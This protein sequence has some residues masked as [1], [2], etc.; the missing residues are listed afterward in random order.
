MVVRIQKKKVN[1]VS[2]DK[3]CMPKK[4]GGLSVKKLF[5]LSLLLNGGGDFVW[6]KKHYGTICY[7]SSMEH[8]D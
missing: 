4:M 2:W 8:S 6:I 3:I 7:Y 5:N 1:W